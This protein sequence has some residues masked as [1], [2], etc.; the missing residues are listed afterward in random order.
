MRETR[1][2]LVDIA[3]EF[4]GAHRLM[5]RLFE[6]HRAG[7]LRF[8]E[9]AALIGDDE[10]SVLFRLKERCHARFRSGGGE[11]LAATRDALFDL[12]VGSLFHEAMKFRE[13]FYQ[14]EVYAPRVEAL[15]SR[16]GQ[17]EALLFEEFA[18]IQDGVTQSLE[19][20]L[21]ET[22][23]L[24]ARTVEQL[25]HLLVAQRDEPLVT[26]FLVENAGEVETA[27][28]RT[29]ASL[30]EQM[31]GDT[32]TGYL[33]AGRSLLESGYYPEAI[34]ALEEAGRH[35]GDAA[36]IGRLEAYAL[37]MQA[38][39]ARDYAQ[40]VAR[41]SEWAQAES[42]RALAL[43]ELAQ[44]AVARVGQLAQGA[45]RARVAKQAGVLLAKLGGPPASAASRHAPRRPLPR[46]DR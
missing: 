22:E 2:G 27:T 45:D 38:Y 46:P 43:T 10:R 7:E 15:R 32:A 20:G 14:R 12:A 36:E 31:H 30:L 19:E 3:R 23:A 25:C 13:S 6:R 24:L 21:A 34:G 44:D 4:L 41:L 39:L 16:A 40:S 37:G 11:D 5:R 26:R 29:V 33:V 9:L 17:E 35:G 8:E 42:P 1:P 28:L 18:R